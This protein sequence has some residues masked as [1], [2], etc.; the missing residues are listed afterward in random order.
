MRKAG[1]QGT[2]KWETAETCTG[3]RESSGLTSRAKLCPSPR[4]TFWGGKRGARAGG[5]RALLS[6]TRRLLGL[7]LLRPAAR[8]CPGRRRRERPLQVPCARRRQRQCRRAFLFLP[9]DRPE[10]PR[11]STQRHTWWAREELAAARAALRLFFRM[12]YGRSFFYW[13]QF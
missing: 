2:A 7:G 4:D 13:C 9:G 6:R 8:R 11:R 3:R 1:A 12:Q 5:L 10:L